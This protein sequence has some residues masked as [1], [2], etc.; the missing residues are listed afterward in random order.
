MLSV[1]PIAFAVLTMIALAASAAQ[2]AEKRVALVIGNAS[3]RSAAV[4][5]NTLND[6]DTI[7]TALKSVGFEVLDGRNLSKDGM[8]KMLGR[9]SKVLQGADAGLVYFAGHG[10]QFEGQNYLLPIDA[11]IEDEFNLRFEATRLEDIISTLHYASG[12]QI[13]ILDACRNNPFVAQLARRSATRDVAVRGGLA[14]VKQTQG[15]LIAYATQA[16][17]VASDGSGRNSPF[18]EAL[19][20]ELKRPG[21]E[22]ATVFRNIQV[23]V[24][25]T[26]KGRQLPEL[27][28]SLLGDFYL[29][30]GETDADAWKKAS[31]SNDQ[32]QLQ[33]FI[34]T[35]PES[36]WAE[37]ARMRLSELAERESLLRE[38][39]KREELIRELSLRA[40]QLGEKIRQAEDNRVKAIKDL[41]LEKERQV[42]SVA[43]RKEEI[44]K[45]E[46]EAS[47]R[48]AAAVH[49][50][51]TVVLTLSAERQ[52]IEEKR[53][54][55]ERASEERLRSQNLLLDRNQD[56][57]RNASLGK[58]DEAAFPQPSTNALS[59]RTSRIAVPKCGEIIARLQLGEQTQSDLDALKQCQK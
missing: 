52:R 38:Y 32:Q 14:P 13:L 3:Y 45:G 6:A 17:D 19:A 25:S 7:S 43:P 44:K 9:F 34:K 2:A 57:E 40:E 48:L 50:Q 23:Q 51:E 33:N 29:N 21:Q 1:P 41:E 39:A 36:N 16:N 18:T 54:S 59:N 12:V 8:G 35:Y 5:E 55:A 31:L 26:T 20:R 4:L 42:T 22:I 37:M 27:S 53:K 58:M 11:A 24:Y 47:E 28:I 30:T 49:E 46:A 56:K 10:L 15:M